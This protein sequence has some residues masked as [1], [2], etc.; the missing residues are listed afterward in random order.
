MQKPSRWSNMRLQ[1]HYQENGK[2]QCLCH[3]KICLLNIKIVWHCNTWQK[4]CYW[5]QVKKKVQHSFSWYFCPHPAISKIINF[6]IR[7]P[8]QCQ[9]LLLKIPWSAPK[10]SENPFVVS[11][12]IFYEHRNTIVYK[13]LGWV[14]CGIIDKLICLDY[15]CL[16]QENPSKQDKMF[17]KIR[18]NYFSGIG[19][20][21]VLMNIMTCQGF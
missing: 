3:L 13:V 14:I 7:S 5:I 19:I 18:F 21:D 10:G 17:N 11:L 2:S 12:M 20:P 15:L 1:F 16:H 6:Y 9:Q 4:I 8:N